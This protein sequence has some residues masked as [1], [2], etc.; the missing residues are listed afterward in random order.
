MEDVEMKYESILTRLES[1]Y[2]LY[3]KILIALSGGVDSCL[4]AYLGRK[5]L[6]R[7]NAVAVISMLC[8]F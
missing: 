3:D 4:A 6:G 5:F 1:E 2:K 8:A 7:E